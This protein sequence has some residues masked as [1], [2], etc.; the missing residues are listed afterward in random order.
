MGEKGVRFPEGK[1]GELREFEHTKKERKLSQ[2]RKKGTASD[3]I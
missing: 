2:A 3:S 1:G